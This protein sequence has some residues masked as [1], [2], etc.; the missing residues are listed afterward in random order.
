MM[1]LLLIFL[2]MLQIT[3]P[4]VYLTFKSDQGTWTSNL[5]AKEYAPQ[6]SIGDFLR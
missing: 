3:Q 5:S 1:H 6:I 4:K 2:R